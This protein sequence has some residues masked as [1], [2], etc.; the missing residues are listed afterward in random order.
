M[1]D[2]RKKP[3]KG[4]LNI[5][6][7]EPLDEAAIQQLQ[8]GLDALDGLFPA[9]RPHAAWF[10]QQIAATHKQQ[11]SRLLGDLLKLWVAALLLLTLLFL[12]AVSLPAAFITFQLLAMIVPLAWLLLRKRVSSHES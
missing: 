6:N 4:G 1:D 11:R 7:E 10:D 5:E 2:N 3:R 8:E 9:P 12:T